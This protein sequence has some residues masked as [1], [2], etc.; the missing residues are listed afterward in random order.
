MCPGLHPFSRATMLFPMRRCPQ[1]QRLP[2]TQWNCTSAISAPSSVALKSRTQGKTSTT[3]RTKFLENSIKPS[4][5]RLL[6]ATKAPLG[7]MSSSALIL[8]SKGPTC[9]CR[10]GPD[11][12][13]FESKP[14]KRRVNRQPYRHH[15]GRATS[16]YTKHNDCAQTTNINT[17]AADRF[18]VPCHF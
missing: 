1:T 9:G 10:A 7:T 12:Q 2:T 14:Q 17:T 8:L 4:E 15:R 3:A 13:I 11:H 16:C 5:I 18:W 6:A